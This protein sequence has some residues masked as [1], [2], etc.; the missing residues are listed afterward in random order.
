MA[1]IQTVQWTSADHTSPEALIRV[2][3]SGAE[4][5]TAVWPN[6]R[7]HWR[8]TIQ[9]W[10]DG[11][12]VIATEDASVAIGAL[13]DEL[14]QEA[15]VRISAQVPEWDSEQII[16]VIASFWNMLGAPNASQDLARDIYVYLT[17]S[18]PAAGALAKADTLTPAEVALVVPTDASPF[19]VVDGAF[20]GWPT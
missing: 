15:I 19:A 9:D 6:N 16:R 4:T 12:G 17:D 10:I 20:P 1:N 18:S 2:T 3:L 8:Q 5:F 7:T 11:G 14:K 13:K